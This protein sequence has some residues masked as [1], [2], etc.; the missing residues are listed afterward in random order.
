V[1]L[2]P[3]AGRSAGTRTLLISAKTRLWR[4]E[5]PVQHGRPKGPRRPRAPSSLR[6]VLL[7]P[8][9]CSSLRIAF[10]KPTAAGLRAGASGGKSQPFCCAT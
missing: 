2:L 8:I 5:S 6:C 3:A 4:R 7:A 10:G 1:P 9:G